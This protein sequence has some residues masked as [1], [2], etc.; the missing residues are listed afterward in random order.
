M[1]I[2]GL[3]KP[4]LLIYS[5]AAFEDPINPPTFHHHL[6]LYACEKFFQLHNGR[7][8]GSSIVMTEHIIGG[9]SIVSD[10]GGA[11]VVGSEGSSISSTAEQQAVDY[12]EDVNEMIQIAED[13][14]VMMNINR[15]A[16]EQD[17]IV[18][19]CREM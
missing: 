18:D 14:M 2:F 7:Y 4:F 8:P 3:L 5:V 6:A 12:D 17:L 9:K 10:D 11:V 16:V 19:A 1:E 15:S 13:V